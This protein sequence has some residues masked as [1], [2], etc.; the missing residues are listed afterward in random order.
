[1]KETNLSKVIILDNYL[2]CIHHSYIQKYLLLQHTDLMWAQHFDYSEK[3][4]IA[5]HPPNSIVV[6]DATTGAKLWKK[7]YNEQLIAMDADPF[8]P[9][10]LACISANIFTKSVSKLLN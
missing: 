10:R 4:L 5:I 1:V 2:I 8:D 9:N 3:Y 6:W 7:I